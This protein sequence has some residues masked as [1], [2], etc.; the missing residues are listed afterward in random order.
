MATKTLLPVCS[1]EA[2]N[3]CFDTERNQIVPKLCRN[4]IEHHLCARDAPQVPFKTYNVV[5]EWESRH[6]WNQTRD[7]DWIARPHEPEH[8]RSGTMT[9][10]VIGLEVGVF[11][12]SIILIYLVVGATKLWFRRGVGKKNI[13]AEQGRALLEKTEES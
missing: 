13:A 9:N 5:E 7:Q 6:A 11:L 8:D 2:E 1:A 10:Q 4:D 12:S 3:G